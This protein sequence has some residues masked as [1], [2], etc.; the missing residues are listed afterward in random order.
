M[1]DAKQILDRELSRA[2]LDHEFEVLNQAVKRTSILCP[3]CN[4]PE[5]SLL[6]SMILANYT[7]YKRKLHPYKRMKYGMYEMQESMRND[8]DEILS[9]IR[10]YRGLLD[11][12]RPCANCHKRYNP[13]NRE[14][15]R[16]YSVDPKTAMKGLIDE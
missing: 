2:M 12:I 15:H 13:N 16:M 6:Y 8:I 11:K 4:Y 9:S 3:N 7:Y 5:N 10:K 14:T 1:L